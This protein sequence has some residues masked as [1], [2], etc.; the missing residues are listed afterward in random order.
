MEAFYVLHSDNVIVSPHN[1]YNTKDALHRIL[2]ITIENLY[3]C[4]KEG[5]PK[6]IVSEKSC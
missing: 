6:N 3:S 4:V 2:D 1:A 5:K